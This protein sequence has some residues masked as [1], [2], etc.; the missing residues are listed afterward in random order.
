MRSTEKELNNE[1]LRVSILSIEDEV[2]QAHLGCSVSGAATKA[3]MWGTEVN[4]PRCCCCK[5]PDVPSYKRDVFKGSP[6]SFMPMR[7]TAI[8]FQRRS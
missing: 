7:S 3:L 1:A 6:D 2:T 5:H 4:K 8:Q